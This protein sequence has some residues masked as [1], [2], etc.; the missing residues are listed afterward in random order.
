MYLMCLPDVGNPQR[1]RIWFEKDVE[2]D[3]DADH[4]ILDVLVDLPCAD[5]S[6]DF[7]ASLLHW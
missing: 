6:L 2:R 3:G 1:E 7:T 5:G 4:V